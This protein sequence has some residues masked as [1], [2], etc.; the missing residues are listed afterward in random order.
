M[1]FFFDFSDRGGFGDFRGQVKL[2]HEK[3]RLPFAEA[4]ARSRAARLFATGSRALGFFFGSMY[5]KRDFL[6]VE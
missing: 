3:L 1:G 2:A 5:C 6:T 4:S